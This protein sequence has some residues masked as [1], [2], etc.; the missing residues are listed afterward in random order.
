MTGCNFFAVALY[1][2]SSTDPDTHTLT[3]PPP[4]RALRPRRP[5]CPLG[6][7]PRTRVS[8]RQGLRGAVG[9]ALALIVQNN[10]LV[11]PPGRDHNVTCPSVILNGTTIVLTALECDSRKQFGAQVVFY[12]A[13]IA[14]LTLLINGTTKEGMREIIYIINDAIVLLAINNTPPF[15]WIHY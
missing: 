13:G 1:S 4:A 2:H 14:L 11:V 6:P 15:L 10:E 12:V 8:F 9:L 5:L 7:F 3:A